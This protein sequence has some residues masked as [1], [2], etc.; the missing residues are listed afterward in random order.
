MKKYIHIVRIKIVVSILFV[1]SI[2]QMQAQQLPQYT[3]YML[4]DFVLNP[5]VAGRSNYWNCVSDNRY[6]WV[7]ITDAP[8]TYILSM[9]C[10]LEGMNMGIGANLYTDIVGPT[11]RVG[12]QAAYSY[13]LKLNS[14]FK[15]NL[16]LSGGMLQYSIDGSKI[17]FNSGYDPVTP[18]IYKSHLTPDFGAGVYLHSEKL[19]LG[20]SVPQMFS[21]EIKFKDQV[22][23]GL[24]RIK[25]HIYLLAGYRLNIGQDFIFEPSVLVKYVTPAP[26]KVDVG[27]RLSYRNKMWIGA[28]YRTNDAVTALVGC[29]YNNWLSFGYSYDYTITTLQQFTTGTHELML[30]VRFSKPKSSYKDDLDD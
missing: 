1:L 8:R 24:S 20:L 18:G 4:N 14:T 13:H 12:F 16:G 5:A 17:T 25:P 22:N 28:N 7:G 2:I 26:V 23:T 30:G 19:Y 27:A 29:M 6:Q 11:R 9:H 10:P 21:A 15:L 3:Q